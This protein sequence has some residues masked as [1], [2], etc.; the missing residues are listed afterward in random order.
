MRCRV[1]NSMSVLALLAGSAP[2]GPADALITGKNAS[3]LSETEALRIGSRLRR[4][5]S[6]RQD[7][8]SLPEL[9][10]YSRKRVRGRQ[11]HPGKRG[12]R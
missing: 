7:S 4:R 2:T 8:M 11:T 10:R 6:H 3:R 12:K 5:W 9:I 1:A